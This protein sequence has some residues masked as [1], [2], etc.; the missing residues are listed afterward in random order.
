MRGRFAIITRRHHTLDLIPEAMHQN[1]QEA[2]DMSR[3]PPE[4]IRNFCIIAH[5]DHGKSTLADRLLQYTG[6][7]SAE[8]KL[9]QV[10]DTLQVERTRGITVKAQAVSL[11]YKCK[12]F[13]GEEYLLNLI[14]TPGHVDFSYEVSR[15]LASC[16]GALLLI[17]AA[18][19]IQ[20]QTM[21]NYWMAKSQGI[22]TILPVL[23]KIDLA[24]ANVSAVLDQ[25]KNAGISTDNLTMISAKNG[26]NI[27]TELLPKIVK[28]LDPPRPVLS[29]GPTRVLLFD[30]W[31][32][33][34]KG[35][36]CLI[37]IIDGE[38]LVPGQ[39]LTSFATQKTYTVQ[40]MGIHTPRRVTVDSLYSGQVGWILLGM[41]SPQEALI[42]DTLYNL[43]E[44][45]KST[46][47]PL[48]GFQKPQAMVFAGVFPTQLSEYVELCDAIHKLCLNDSSITL[49]PASSTILGKGWRVG[50]LGTLHMDVFKQRLEQEYGATVIFTCPTVPY[51]FCMDKNDIGAKELILFNAAEDIP[52][53]K[54]GTHISGM[55][56]QP[57][58]GILKEPWIEIEIITPE[59]SMGSIMSLCLERRGQQISVDYNTSLGNDHRVT[60]V[61]K[62]PLAEI[63]YDFYEL[64]KQFS[65]GYANIQYR[66]QLPAADKDHNN[67]FGTNQL[68]WEYC[69]VD[70]VQLFINDRPVPDMSFLAHP[71]KAQPL[72][73]SLLAAL[74][75][76]IDRQVFEVVLQAKVNVD[77]RGKGGRVLAREA[78]SAMRKD[79]TAKC[80]GGD[81]T[82]KQKLLEHQKECKKKLKMIGQVE[83]KHEA[84]LALMTATSKS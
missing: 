15:S 54:A 41:K 3:F 81:K 47:I 45:E 12:Q 57:Q 60:M 28:H 61:Y 32:D 31:Y 70:L 1:V 58:K 53:L 52:A 66:Q 13:E 21:S 63:I 34:Y 14:D 50:F 51:M 4:R 79:V 33:Q 65:S 56:W 38:R 82:R 44:D 80:Y 55:Q 68:T 59:N 75:E 35:V 2:K 8:Q 67:A 64:V 42:G 30:S 23:N 26:T 72:G 73:R 48:P 25:M 16:Q 11:F 40:S 77:E 49:A 24:S 10:L 22:K 19:G 71:S 74:K 5:V 17:D 7:I 37:N 43:K 39:T 78:I 46:V 76:H 20:A 62:I 83:L 18:Q 36:V 29:R 69:D 84:F 6:A 9:S 27:S